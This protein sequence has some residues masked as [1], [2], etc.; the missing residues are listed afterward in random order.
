MNKFVRLIFILF[1]LLCM[2]VIYL[3][4]VDKYSVVYDM[5]PTI[6]QGSLSNNNNDGKVFPD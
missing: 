4:T 5:D 6:P 1:Y 3:S 2:L